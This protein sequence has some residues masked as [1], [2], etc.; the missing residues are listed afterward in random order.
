MSRWPEKKE[1]VKVEV[2]PEVKAE[3][4]KIAGKIVCARCKH[5]YAEGKHIIRE[6]VKCCPNCLGYATLLA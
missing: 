2:K 4:V 1:E 3:P 5:E 6:Q